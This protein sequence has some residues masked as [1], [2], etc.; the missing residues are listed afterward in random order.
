M[1]MDLGLPKYKVTL[2]PAQSVSSAI[3]AN[4]TAEEREEW[5][6]HAA[7]ALAAAFR[8]V[9]AQA[10]GQKL[11][12]EEVIASDTASGSGSEKEPFGRSNPFLAPVLENRRITSPDHFQDVR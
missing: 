1:L 3:T 12:R 4:M 5:R 8:R 10:S 11:L 6:L 9:T 2:L 7:V